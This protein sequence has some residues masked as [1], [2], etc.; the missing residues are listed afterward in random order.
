MDIKIKLN[1]SNDE[2]MELTGLS[3]ELSF[4]KM[5]NRT[6]HYFSITSYN[7]KTYLNI[8]KNIIDKDKISPIK[9]LDVYINNELALHEEVDNS[10]PSGI[11]IVT[12]LN[13]QTNDELTTNLEVPLLFK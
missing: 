6:R 13:T 9:N 10:A 2:S 11:Y 1:F 5:Y 12:A 7:P 3:D 4:R 8:F